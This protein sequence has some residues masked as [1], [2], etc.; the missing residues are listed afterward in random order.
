MYL[1]L[2]T[3]SSQ[4]IQE[5]VLT[6]PHSTTI[7]YRRARVKRFSTKGPLGIKTDSTTKRT[8]KSTASSWLK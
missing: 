8:A 6:V 4:Q 3:V 2:Q 7:T 1:Y 5:L